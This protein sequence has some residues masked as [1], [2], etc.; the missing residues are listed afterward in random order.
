[1]R[2]PGIP[3]TVRI[4]GLVVIAVVV[5]G[6]AVTLSAGFFVS[7]GYRDLSDREMAVT[8]MAVRKSVE[9]FEKS[10]LQFAEYGAARKD[11]AEAVARKNRTTLRRV[12]RDLMDIRSCDFITISD[13]DGDVLVRG[14]SDRVGDDLTNHTNVRKALRGESSVCFEDGN[15]VGFSLRAGSPIRYNGEIA[16]CITVGVD[17]LGGHAF[18]DGIKQR[19]GV[20]CTIFRGDKRASTT[21]ERDGKRILGTKMDNTEVTRTVLERNQSYQ[22]TNRIQ[23]NTYNT[24]YWPVYSADRTVSGMLFIGKNQ[25]QNRKSYH[26]VIYAIL[27]S[28]AVVG[29]AMTWLGIL[30]A[31]SVAGPVSQVTDSLDQNAHQ[32]F[33][34]AGQMSGL[35]EQ[36]AE[37]TCSQASSL[38]EI[39]SSVH[40]MTGMTRQ[41]AENARMCNR[42]MGETE[43]SFRVVGE[44]LHAM[45]KT[46]AGIQ[47]NSS[48]TERIIKSINEIAFQTNLLALNAA[49]EAARAGV[50]GAGFA[51]VADE[52]RNLAQR[53]SAAAGET[54]KLI[55]HT[56]E[57]IRHGAEQSPNWVMLLTG[58]GR[59]DQRSGNWLL[60]SRRP[61]TNRRPGSTRSTQRFPVLKVLRRILLPVPRRPPRRGRN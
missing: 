15:E 1:M 34:A 53:A 59:L 52:V 2:F 37:E 12:V 55:E 18:V 39:S 9:E 35:T 27:S 41:N 61:P 49:V 43:V 4:A 5:V 20:D 50:H 28:L 25:E 17:I 16:G 47:R 26:E 33:T 48:E 6:G 31:R 46:F 7:R 45:V 14:H 42:F 38:E 44:K 3:F 13:A 60:K 30:L 56:A 23:E 10:M 24:I 11:I 36:L 29:F 40:E 58:T 21:I 8:S 57:S 22:G 54:Q 32:V 19:F 51:V